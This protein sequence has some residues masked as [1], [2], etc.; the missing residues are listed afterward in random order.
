MHKISVPRCH[1]TID[2]FGFDETPDVFKKI[3][4]SNAVDL[5][6]MGSIVCLTGYF[7]CARNGL[8]RA[9]AMQQK[10]NGVNA[11]VAES[12]TKQV[13]VLVV[14][15]KARVISS[16]IKMAI[17]KDIPIIRENNF[18]QIVRELKSNMVLI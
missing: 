1:D 6:I 4:F 5:G 2:M 13:D 7:D 8:R 18:L 9:E 12:W 11:L 14:G 16:K 17:E 3:D 15:V 10:I